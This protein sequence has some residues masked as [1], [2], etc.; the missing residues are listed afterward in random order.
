M[1]TMAIP[2]IEIDVSIYVK[3]LS[4][5]FGKFILLVGYSLFTLKINLSL[6][7]YQLLMHTGSTSSQYCVTYFIIIIIM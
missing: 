6:R 7:I 5:N 4:L 3:Q 2:V 1:I